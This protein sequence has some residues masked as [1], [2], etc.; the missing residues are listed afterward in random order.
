MQT[1]VGK[2]TFNEAQK[3]VLIAAMHYG[4]VYA[5]KPGRRIAGVLVDQYHSEYVINTLVHHAKFRGP[6]LMHGRDGA[7]VLTIEGEDMA[8]E[9]Y[10]MTFTS[11]IR[12]HQC[13][14]YIWNEGKYHEWDLRWCDT[15][16]LFTLW[17]GD[18]MWGT[19]E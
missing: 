18:S 16:K 3:A 9:L 10:A 13:N 2:A 12:C 5:S 1:K 8:Q 11:G 19:L 7:Y 4:A 17:D 14:D 15:C 6:V